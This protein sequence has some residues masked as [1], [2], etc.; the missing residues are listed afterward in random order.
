MACAAAGSVYTVSIWTHNAAIFNWLS[1][2][3]IGL[4][5]GLHKL[6]TCQ[7]LWGRFQNSQLNSVGW[8]LKK[9]N[10]HKI[11]KIQN[12]YYLRI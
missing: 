11:D 8:K 9:M 1:S 12:K 3:E 6:Y 7:Q 4:S 10:V 5:S 2:Q